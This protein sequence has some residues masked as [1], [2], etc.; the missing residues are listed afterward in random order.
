VGSPFCV[1]NSRPY[2]LPQVLTLRLIYLSV[3]LW[4]L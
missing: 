2:S 1:P 3:C 4:Q